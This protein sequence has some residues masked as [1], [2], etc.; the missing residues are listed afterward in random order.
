MPFDV[1]IKTNNG[2]KAVNRQQLRR[3]GEC[4]I[5][6]G[7]VFEPELTSKGNLDWV[8]WSTTARLTSLCLEKQI[9]D[10]ATDSM[11][12]TLHQ[13]DGRDPSLR[14]QRIQPIYG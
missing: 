9:R 5:G 4:P 13:L 7:T 6:V 8:G 12:G 3:R 1:D 2:L 14:A 11:G 10:K